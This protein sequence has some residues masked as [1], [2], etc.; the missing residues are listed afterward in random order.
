MNP[1]ITL[2]IVDDEPMVLS[3]LRDQLLRLTGGRSV[4]VECAGS[5]AEAWEVID[6]LDADGVP[7]AMVVSDWLMPQT[8]GDV[9]LSG[10]RVRCQRARRVLLTGQAD[11]DVLQRMLGDGEVD[12]LLFKPWSEQDL[13][14]A[15]ALA[16]EA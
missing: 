7:L 1:K 13:L 9:F 8:R 3:S 2:L 4:S 12:R 11:N 15:M 6:E 10:V 5:V 16:L 14:D